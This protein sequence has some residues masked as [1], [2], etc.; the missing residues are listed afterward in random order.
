[1]EFIAV[2]DERVH[3]FSVLLFLLSGGRALNFCMFSAVD[4]THLI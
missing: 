3:L 4:D 2:V 1:M